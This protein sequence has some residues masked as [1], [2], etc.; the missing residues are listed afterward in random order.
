M[1][2][3]KK[4]KIYL[5]LKRDITSGRLQSGRKLPSEPELSRKLGVGRITLRASLYQ[6]EQEGF[7]K[8]IRGKG[9]FVYPD[10][11]TT[12]AATIMV[13]HGTDSGFEQTWHYIVPEICRYAT[14]KQLKVFITTNAAIN[15]F[16]ESDIREFAKSNHIIGIVA[17][18]SYFI[19]NEPILA[20]MR[21]AGVPIVIAPGRMDDAK[22]TG[23]ACIS[24][25]EKDGWEA[26]IA[27]LSEL[28]HK[29]IGLIG[30]STSNFRGYSLQETLQL[31]KKYHVTPDESLIRTVNFDRTDVIETTKAFCSNQATRPTAILCFSDFYAIYVYDALRELKLRIPKDVAVMGLSGYPDARLLN[32]PL[33]TID[34]GY[35]KSAKMAVEMLQEPDKWFDPVISKGKPRLIPFKLIRRQSTE[36][37]STQKQEAK[38]KT[39]G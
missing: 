10:G 18:M 11:A 24:F 14:E 7:I 21:A 2:E 13:I 5:M 3:F 29:R 17:L 36:L 16:S 31:L 6:L 30:H 19:G 32:P 15:M 35:A 28:G 33:S 23:L 8:R 22:N 26:A 4:D 34:F 27:Y 39:T 38:N 37:K 1:L 20:K 25:T 9:T 12:D